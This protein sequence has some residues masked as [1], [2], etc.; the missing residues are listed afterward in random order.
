MSKFFCY[1]PMKVQVINPAKTLLKMLTTE[2][3]FTLASLGDKTQI[4][5]FLFVVA[6]HQ[7]AWAIA[8]HVIDNHQQIINLKGSFTW[9][10]FAAKAQENASY[11]AHKKCL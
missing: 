10:T 2:V 11:K 9:A 1:K 5:L 4:G 3:L 6:S 7:V 8:A